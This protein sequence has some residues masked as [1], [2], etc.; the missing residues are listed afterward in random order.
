MRLFL[1]ATAA[2]ALSGCQTMQESW[3]RTWTPPASSTSTESSYS[4]AEPASNSTSTTIQIA[5]NSRQQLL[6]ME[7]ELAAAAQERGLGSAIAEVIDPVDGFVVRPGATYEGAAAVQSGLAVAVN[8]P[9]FWQPDKIFVS[10]AG[11]MGLTSGRYVQVVQGTEA[12][13]GRYVIVWR[14]DSLGEWKALSETRTA[15]PPSAPTVTTA[16]RRRR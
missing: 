4:T 10:A 2:T 14:R 8:R 3:D 5:P 6:E 7:R 12:I 16:R 1:L 13:Q 15:D 9:I 11:D